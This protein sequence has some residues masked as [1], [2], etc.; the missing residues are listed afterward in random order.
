MG[1]KVKGSKRS[2]NVE[3]RERGCGRGVAYTGEGCFQSAQRT[4]K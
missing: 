3:E 4:H 2:K 1:M